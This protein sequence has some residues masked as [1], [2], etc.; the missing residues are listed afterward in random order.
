VRSAFHRLFAAAAALAALSPLTAACSGGPGLE[1]EKLGDI[2]QAVT[3][4]GDWS[5]YG[6]GQ[7]VTGAR[8]FYTA[9]F[10]VT[11]NATGLQSTD[12]GSCAALG[13]CMYWVSPKVAPSSATWVKYAWGSEMPKTYDLIIYPP[14]GTNAYGHVAS[15][16][17]MEGTNPSDLTKL[18]VMDSNY[19]V[20]VKK[21]P[22]IHTTT[23]TPYGFYRLK[24][25]LGPFC[26][27]G[28][29]AHLNCG[30]EAGLHDADKGTLYK[31]SGVTASVVQK[32]ANGCVN[33]PTGTDDHCAP[34]AGT[35][36]A[37]TGAEGGGA[38]APAI[39]DAGSA[40]ETG[41]ADDAGT[42]D[43]AGPTNDGGLGLEAGSDFVQAG[44][45]QGGGCSVNGVPGSAGGASVLALLAA[46]A[47]AG[48]RRR[49]AQRA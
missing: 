19:T 45:E 33:A 12:I 27:P 10:G 36:D 37:A 14:H 1:G 29:S 2:A 8:T 13:A 24:S 39:N 34:T 30:D 49:G 16:D 41:G 38:D 6:D 43:D 17:H 47:L 11:L 21:S 31:C 35:Q 7:C 25:Q 4:Y 42:P 22:S 20:S 5:T 18:Y 32:C 40:D 15:V 9:K 46:A 28:W 23:V 26:S 3:T 44:A 48:R